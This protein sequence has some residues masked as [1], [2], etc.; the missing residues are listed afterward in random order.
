MYVSAIGEY[1]SVST[2]TDQVCKVIKSKEVS[3]M[4]PTLHLLWNMLT[5]SYKRF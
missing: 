1:L 3:W 5:Q 2:T 4:F